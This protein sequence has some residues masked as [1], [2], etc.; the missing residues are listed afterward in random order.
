MPAVVRQ[1]V[2]SAQGTRSRLAVATA[3]GGVMLWGDGPHVS[4]M[5]FASEM[6]EPRIA[7]TRNGSLIAASKDEIDVY[8]TADGRLKLRHRWAGLGSAP[9]A[10]LTTR[11]VNRFAT[12][13]ADGRICIFDVAD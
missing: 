13:Q 6:V 8:S 1:L 3:Q 7:L 5:P 12:V 11:L 2:G 4:R 9:L 10:V